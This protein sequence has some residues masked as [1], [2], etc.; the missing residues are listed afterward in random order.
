[1]PYDP[2][3][4]AKDLQSAVGTDVV[5]QLVADFRNYQVG[6]SQGPAGKVTVQGAGTVQTGTDG[7]KHTPHQEQ[8]GWVKPPQVDQWKPPGLSVMDRM[9]DQ[10]DALDKAARAKQLIEAAAQLKALEELTKPK[11]PE[12]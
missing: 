8:G 2:F 10:A 3:Q 12:K 7:A 9:M 4:W 11:E 6:P 5:K 1:M